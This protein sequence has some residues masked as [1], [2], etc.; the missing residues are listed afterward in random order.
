MKLKLV[1]LS[2]LSAT[3]AMLIPRDQNVLVPNKDAGAKNNKSC[4]FVD[5][6]SHLTYDLNKLTKTDGDYK[7]EIP[8]S[9]T[10]KKKTFNL[11]VCHALVL[12]NKGLTDSNGVAISVQEGEK[13]KSLGKTNTTLT[14]VNNRIIANYEEGDNCPGVDIRRRKTKIIFICDK[15]ISDN[16]S[17][18]F[19]DEF[20]SCHYVIEWKTPLVCS[21]NGSTS[22][23]GSSSGWMIFFKVI[24]VLGLIY[25]FAGILYN[26]FAKGAQGL[27]QIPHFNFWYNAFDFVKD[28]TLIIGIKVWDSLMSLKS[29]VSSRYQSVP[30]NE[31]HI[32]VN[33]DE[34]D[35]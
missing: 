20:E 3:L 27:E 25:L 11:N 5:E 21:I 28:M 4:T 29:K 2:Y 34:D 35:F 24:A 15:S 30:R 7:I 17:P 23:D 26:R 33:D 18:V 14:M 31:G 12:P 6:T 19:L 16:G 13:V 32:L 9:K 8:E 22:D 10:S 1:I